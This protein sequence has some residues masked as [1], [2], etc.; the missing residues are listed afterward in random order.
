VSC[1]QGQNESIVLVGFVCIRVTAVNVTDRREGENN[2]LTIPAFYIYVCSE[3][4]GRKDSVREP[5]RK[6]RKG[7]AKARKGIP[8]VSLRSFFASFAV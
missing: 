7:G 6:E 2:E 4:A 1:A 5:N 8:S 3:P